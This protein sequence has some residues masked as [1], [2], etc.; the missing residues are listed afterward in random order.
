MRLI[1]KLFRKYTD[2]S[3]SK[4]KFNR[5]FQK[6]SMKMKLGQ[7]SP[8]SLKKGS[9]NL[10]SITLGDN[11]SKNIRNQPSLFNQ[12]KGKSKPRLLR[13][14]DSDVDVLSRLGRK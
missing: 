12:R 1:N 13:T 8:K 5:A 3:D 6:I 9:S 14:Y 11:L 10:K 4:K 2:V 7:L